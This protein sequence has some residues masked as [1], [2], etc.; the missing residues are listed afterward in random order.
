MRA[1][2]EIDPAL[3][4]ELRRLAVR[5]ALAAG[6]ELRRH[7]GHVTGLATKSTATDPVSD[8]DRAS[9]A[10]LTSRILDARPD[11][12][13]LGEEGADRPSRTGLRWVLDPL[14]GTVNYLYGLPAWSVS[15]CC[16]RADGADQGGSG[17]ESWRGLVAVV[18]DPL[19]GETF[20]A[21]RD[22]GAW[23]G[24][25]RLGVNDPVPLAQAL[26]ATG[27]AYD[28]ER[29]A[30][31]AATVA[32]LLP[33]VRDVRRVGSAA[34]D[35]CWL[36]AGRTDAFFEDRLGRWDWAGG[37]LIAREAGAAMTPLDQGLLAA[38]P[39]LHAELA[40]LLAAGG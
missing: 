9:E 10:L 8:A 40:A 18:H 39:S 24:G 27:F 37:G 16:E 22:Q 3:L 30:R 19:R 6:D 17:G 31:Q 21:I 35:L 34:L 25:R 15:V 20:T 23:L 1:L 33:T 2:A 4:E 29:R 36:A 13:L 26:I 7:Q 5:A 38:G 32:R 28:A 11:D 14:D 12:G